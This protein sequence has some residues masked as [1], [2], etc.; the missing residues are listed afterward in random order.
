[1]RKFIVAKKIVASIRAFFSLVSSYAC[2]AASRALLDDVMRRVTAMGWGGGGG[3]LFSFFPV[4]SETG[5]QVRRGSIKKHPNASNF[6][7]SRS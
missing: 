5:S 4:G 2:S 1:V 3:K 7:I 6:V